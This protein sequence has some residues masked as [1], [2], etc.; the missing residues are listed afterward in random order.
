MNPSKWLWQLDKWPEF[1]YDKE[2][3]TSLENRFAQ[4]AGMVLGAF[5]H[6]TDADQTQ[7][8][9]DVL[10]DEALKT[11]EI[12]G[13]YLNRDSIQA[14]I[15]NNLGLQTDN[16]KIPPE[17]Y[18]IATMMV[19]L[20]QSYAE[21]LTHETLFDWHLL[22]TNGR[23]DLND[24]GRYRT[25][26]D[27]MQI[28]SGRLDVPKVHYEAPPSHTMNTE[29][30]QFIEW[31]NKVHTATVT[32]TPLVR[33]GMTH[34]YFL[35]IHPFED[36]NGRIGRALAEKSIAMSLQQPALLSLS[37]T[38]QNHKKVYYTA[39]ESHNRTLN[40]T[41]WLVY[42][43]ETI[44]LAQE[45]TLLLLDFTIEKGKFFGRYAAE[46]NER[47][48]KVIKRMFAEGYQG[49][50]GGL[51]ADNYIR[52]SKTSPS[53]ATRDL[54]DMIDKGILRKSGKRR[55]TRY[56]LNIKQY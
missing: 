56:W 19:K 30:N 21:P 48:H 22:L 9:I 29:M 43:G 4:G 42:F 6:V 12:E 52:I 39:L 46:L 45:N 51:S 3:V 16:R 27:A 53:T 35:S 55:G 13:E 18:G 24:I 37:Q 40:I 34:L 49:F 7:F 5:K 50:Q 36:G 1:S 28:V 38:I 33:A 26:T 14:S 31:F 8:I 11:S 2:A 10:S 54:Q 44:L 47:Q 15:R 17:E 20:Y 25:H 23:Q 41:D 32:M